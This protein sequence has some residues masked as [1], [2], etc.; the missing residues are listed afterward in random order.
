MTEEEAKTKWCPFTRMVFGYDKGTTQPFNRFM[1]EPGDEMKKM[2]AA[3]NG[4]N[5]TK[6]IGS[7]C[8][9]WVAGASDDVIAQAKSIGAGVPSGSR[10]GLVK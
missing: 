1:T 6:C 9:M 5:G 8:M 7:D 3:M 4:T 10:C 2:Q